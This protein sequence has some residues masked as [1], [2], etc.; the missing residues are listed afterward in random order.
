MPIGVAAAC[1]KSHPRTA[2][3][4]PHTYSIAP[5]KL[6]PPASGY[7]NVDWCRIHGPKIDS[8]D[9]IRTL[10]AGPPHAKRADRRN[11]FGRVRLH[12]EYVSSLTFGFVRDAVQLPLCAY[13][14][15][16]WAR[17]AGVQWVVQCW[18][19]QWWRRRRLLWSYSGLAFSIDVVRACG[20]D[21]GSAL[22]SARTAGQAVTAM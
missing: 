4:H 16:R 11:D 20:V 1:H 14:A 10:A 22:R 15:K 21:A 9:A 5:C 2:N 8:D 13:I 6:S 7:I 3:I 12:H 18:R 17:P 19:C